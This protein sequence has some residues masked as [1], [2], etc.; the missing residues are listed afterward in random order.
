[1]A[2]LAQRIDERGK[3]G[4]RATAELAEYHR[5]FAIP[6]A[7]VRVRPPRPPPRG[8]AGPRGQ[9]ARLHAL[10]HGHLRLLHSAVRGAGTGRARARPAG[11]GA[12]AAERRPRD[13]RRDPLPPRPPGAA[14][15]AGAADPPRTGRPRAVASPAPGALGAV[16][17]TNDR[18]H[19][20]TLGRYLQRQVLRFFLLSLATLAALSLIADFFDRVDTFLKHGASLGIVLRSFLLR[21][22]Q[23][24]TEVTPVAML[25]GALVGLGL[26][27]RHREFVALRACGV[28]SWQ[29][30]RPLVAL[31]IVVSA[32]TLA[33]NELVVPSSA[34]RWHEVWNH[35]V[36]KR[37]S[38][39]LRRP[40]GM[41]SRA[42]G[43][44]NIERANPRRQTLLGLTIYQLA[45]R[46]PPRARDHGAPRHLGWAAVATARRRDP[47]ARPGRHPRHA[48]GAGRLHAP[49][50]PR[51]LQRGR[52]RARGLR[53]P[54]AS[55][56]D[57]GICRKKA[58]TP[59]RAGSTCT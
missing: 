2:A 55:A 7:C 8:P 10:A 37:R 21:A 25:A 20:P 54:H 51:R 32:S 58:S 49:R 56:A 46:V 22:P 50:N 57:A 31:A 23:V 33:W 13:R 47:R 4:E 30:L 43:F 24:V 1:M 53:L 3:A 18:V 34:R 39:G 12:L 36:K 19:S 5:R 44:Y 26:M 16:T 27:A 45:R 38:L 11:A 6:F 42:A 59:R 9:V 35:D 28:S 48:R 29:V 41:V 15:P 14:R 52:A 40:A 17:P